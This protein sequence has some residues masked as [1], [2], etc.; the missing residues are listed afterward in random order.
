M[1]HAKAAVAGIAM[2]RFV[3]LTEE[4]DESVCLFH[5]MF[6]G[7][8]NPAEFKDFHPHIGKSEDYDEAELGG[9]VDEADELVYAAAARQFAALKAVTRPEVCNLLRPAPPRL[10]DGGRGPRPP[11]TLAD[12]PGAPQAGFTR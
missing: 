2:M 3:G 12:R 7:R 8:V 11:R 1:S 4:W 9:F 10:S 6:G 5:R